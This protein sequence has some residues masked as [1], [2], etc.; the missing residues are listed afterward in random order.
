MKHNINKHRYFTIL[1]FAYVY[2][3]ICWLANLSPEQYILGWELVLI[4]HSLIVM[5]NESAYFLLLHQS[6]SI[7]RALSYQL[8]TRAHRVHSPTPSTA[9][10]TL[11]TTSLTWLSTRRRE[12]QVSSSDSLHRCH[13]PIR[14]D[15][16]GTGNTPLAE[17]RPDTSRRLTIGP[18]AL[19]RILFLSVK[20]KR[21]GI[22]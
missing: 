20:A 1:W 4:K 18:L 12:M 8:I 22:P 3:Y 2:I 5:Y 7:S 19:W 6:I 11:T 15:V 21:F 9:T 14:R 10:Q 13:W 16:I 17:R